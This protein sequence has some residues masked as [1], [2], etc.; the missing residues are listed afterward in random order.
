MQEVTE[1]GEHAN[2]EKEDLGFQMLYNDIN[3]HEL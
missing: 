3:T 2:I 1:F